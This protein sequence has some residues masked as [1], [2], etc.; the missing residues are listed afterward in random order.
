MINVI[1]NYFL[2]L[3]AMYKLSIFTVAL[4]RLYL[5]LKKNIIYNKNRKAK[6]T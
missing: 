4:K 3:K 2:L 5:H 6:K 1:G